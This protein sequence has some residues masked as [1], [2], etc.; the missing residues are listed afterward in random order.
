MATS[1][2]LTLPNEIQSAIIEWVLR[3]GEIASVCLVSKQL[4]A[5]ALP[6]LYRS[7]SI[8]VDRWTREHRKRIRMRGHIGHKHIRTLDVDSN[9]I[10]SEPAALKVA[11]DILQVLP[12]DS[13]DAFR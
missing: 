11:K 1:R 9:K 2:F 10:A 4:S 3:P 7:V 5:I 13:L 12:R 8:N 6:I